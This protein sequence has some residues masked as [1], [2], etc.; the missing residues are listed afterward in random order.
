[1]IL[2][3]VGCGVVDSAGSSIIH[4][5]SGCAGLVLLWLTNPKQ[6]QKKKNIK[7]ILSNLPSNLSAN[8][9]L[10][11]QSKIGEKVSGKSGKND[12]RN[13]GVEK[14]LDS[15]CITPV[16]KKSKNKIRK[17]SIPLSLPL[18]S[19]GRSSSVASD[20]NDVSY[21]RNTEVLD[22]LF[23]DRSRFS[24][25]SISTYS[26][27]NDKKILKNNKEGN[28]GNL[29]FRKNFLFKRENSSYTNISY[30]SRINNNSILDDIK[31][32]STRELDNLDNVLVLDFY[33]RQVIST[34]C[35][36]TL[37]WIGFIGLNIV[38]NLPENNS[39]SIAGKR[40]F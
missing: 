8:A 19:E 11:L 37:I 18:L 12:G 40:Y 25:R 27:T 20:S 7:Q 3:Y 34:L 6:I 21:N 35:S 38:T 10:N 5:S 1:M 30:T 2:K 13:D 17:L 26:N 24:N 29:S 39:S 15:K 4:M 9:S 32:L 31:K 23:R 36:P 28:I 14:E 16:R 22:P 33:H